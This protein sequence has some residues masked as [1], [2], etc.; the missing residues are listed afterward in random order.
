MRACVVNPPQKRNE[1]Q[2]QEKTTKNN[3][4]GTWYIKGS[5]KRSGKERQFFF[6]YVSGEALRQKQKW[7]V[8]EK[9][10]MEGKNMTTSGHILKYIF[11]KLLSV[12]A[13]HTHSHCFGRHEAIVDDTQCDQTQ[14]ACFP[15]YSWWCKQEKQKSEYE[16]V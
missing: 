1:A 9:W 3:N 4:G 5:R 14:K 11:D 12:S 13:C 6:L 15:L 2:P 7:K 8:H 16:Y 10:N